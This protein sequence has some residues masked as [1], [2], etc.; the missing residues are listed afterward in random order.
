[1]Y[2]SAGNAALTFGNKMLFLCKNTVDS[3]KMKLPAARDFTKFKQSNVLLIV[4]M[5]FLSL[6]RVCN[7]DEEQ[8][9]H[10]PRGEIVLLF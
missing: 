1:M 9:G 8:Q 3:M 6:D 5:C 7:S 2:A 4:F 10:V